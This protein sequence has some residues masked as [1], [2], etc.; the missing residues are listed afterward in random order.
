MVVGVPE[1]PTGSVSTDVEML[2]EADA[3]FV[4]NT[5]DEPLE[6]TRK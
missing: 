5:S 3:V 2:P 1:V 6:P 4:V